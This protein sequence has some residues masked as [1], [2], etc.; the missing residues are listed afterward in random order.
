M[1]AVARIAGLPLPA[2]CLLLSV[3]LCVSGCEKAAPPIALPPPKADEVDLPEPAAIALLEPGT[4]IDAKA[5]PAGVG[6]VFRS[7]PKLTSGDVKKVG[8]AI[9]KALEE[10]TTLVVIRSELDPARPGKF[11]RRD[12]L[13]GIGKPGEK[14]D[15]VVT[16]EAADKLG[17]GLGMFESPV[18]EGRQEE[19]AT[20]KSPGS[21]STMAMYDFTMLV[22]RD[23]KNSPV[24]ARYMAVIN[25]D[26]GTARTA[27]WSLDVTP[28]GY[29][30]H[31]DSLCELPRNHV[32]DWEMH[33]N[34]KRV[35]L[36][37]APKADALTSTKLPQGSLLEVSDEF[38]K[39]AAARSF[40]EATGA[41]LEQMMRA[42]LR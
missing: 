33:V 40:S 5:P 23:D 25:P 29:V 19:L 17:V 10:Y 6:V 26:D 8:K 24:V 11:R 32:M 4:V 36:I 15:L 41:R 20:V 9:R 21:T 38:K 28:D 3:L 18:L 22:R 42:L 7:Q 1:R 2:M 27:H 37:G 13:I 31:E 12:H 35:S 30:F 14:G 34:G 16:V 39:A